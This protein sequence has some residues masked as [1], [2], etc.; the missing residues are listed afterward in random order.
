MVKMNATVVITHGTLNSYSNHKCRCNPCR[1]AMSTYSKSLKAKGLPEG[2][3]R[4]GTYAGYNHY[5]CTCQSCSDIQR[6]Y[7]LAYKR[8]IS[9]EEAN[10]LR[11]ALQCDL[12][13]NEFGDVVPHV[14]HSHDT[15]KVRG[16]LC[17]RCNSSL[18]AFENNTVGKRTSRW[19]E[20]IGL[21]TVERY[22]ERGII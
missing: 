17:R 11:T 1:E 9:L 10:T 20:E 19:L 2:D 3:A 4:H 21:T 18:A 15:E 22:I 5:A 16:S 12:C 8:G 13:S 6:L 7:K 14:D